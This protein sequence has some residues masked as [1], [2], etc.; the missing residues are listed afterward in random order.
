[1]LKRKVFNNLENWKNRENKKCL[2]V[3]GARQVGKTYAVELFGKKNYSEVITLNFKQNPGYADVFSGD[4]DVD[5]MILALRFRLPDKKIQPGESLIFL[6]EI[7]ECEEAIT[8]LKFWSM[9]G[10]YDVI[11]SG[12][13]LG[14]D[15][16]RASSYPV[17]YVDYINMYGLDFEEYLWAVGVK[18]ELINELKNNFQNIKPVQESINNVMMNHFRSFIAVGG[19]PEVVQSFVNTKDYREADRIQKDILQGYLY[20]IAHYA[21]SFEKIKAEKCFLSLSGQLLDK[22]NHKFQY[23][24]VEKGGR[25]QK[26]Y[27]SIE[28]LERANIVVRSYNVSVLKYDLK[29]YES[30]D[31]FRVYTEDISLLMAMRDYSLKEVVL[32]KF[33]TENTKGGLYEAAI[34]DLLIKK[35]NK[36]HFYKN[37]SNKREIEFLI[38]DESGIIPIEVKGGRAKATS[39]NQ[40]MKNNKSIKK[41]YKLIDGN[42]GLSDTGIITM[43]LYMVMFL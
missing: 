31:N 28:W 6:D 33:V 10:R 32:N 20:D 39:L 43:P 27:S 22:D 14:I 24:K 37:E 3:Q 17:G 26:F 8:S 4:L 5:S 13:L 30:E 25:A 2:I 35:G 41:A 19:M 18:E 15:Y 21:N 7:Q 42:I 23:K 29:D 36:L 9:D 38:Q 12:S 40:L 11:A 34:A 1:M 16:K